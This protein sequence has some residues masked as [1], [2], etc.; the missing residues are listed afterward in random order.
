MV[1]SWSSAI[2][3]DLKKT[4]CLTDLISTH[5]KT[6]LHSAVPFIPVSSWW[7]RIFLSTRVS[8]KLCRVMAGFQ[9]TESHEEQTAPEDP[10]NKRSMREVNS[11]F[12]YTNRTQLQKNYFVI[13][14][15]GAGGH[16]CFNKVP[17]GAL[18]LCGF[19]LWIP[20]WLC[21][22]LLTLLVQ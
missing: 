14:V 10:K 18:S 1:N 7:S 9:R 3:H 5:N 16:S 6:W 2:N 13:P 22:S 19:T 20:Y 21:L 11:G 12:S 8:S 17:S 15:C 4:N